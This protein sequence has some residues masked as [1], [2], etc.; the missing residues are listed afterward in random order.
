MSA[1]GRTRSDGPLS[2]S[3]FS[4]ACL[5]MLGRAKQSRSVWVNTLIYAAVAANKPF[6]EPPGECVAQALEAL[7]DHNQDH[8]DR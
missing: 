5:T 3:K 8:D 7:D 4:S 1:R 6:V 2:Q